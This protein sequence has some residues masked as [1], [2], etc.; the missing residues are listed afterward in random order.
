MRL[1]KLFSLAKGFFVLFFIGAFLTAFHQW[2]YSNVPLFTQYLIKTLL[3]G[4]PA[5]AQHVSKK[6]LVNPLATKFP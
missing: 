6:S 5:F 3:E 2:T 1:I 4:F